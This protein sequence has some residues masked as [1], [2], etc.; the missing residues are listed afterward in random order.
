MACSVKL[1]DLFII[2]N[3][4][5]HKSLLET[6]KQRKN[7]PETEKPQEISSKTEIKALTNKALIGSRISLSVFNIYTSK[8]YFP[9]FCVF[10]LKCRTH[11]N[12]KM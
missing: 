8:L 1:M 10:P 6:E 4:G 3:R 7:S 5:G 12:L 2:I 11:R 9:K